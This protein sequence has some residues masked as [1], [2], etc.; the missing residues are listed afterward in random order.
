VLRALPL[1]AALIVA[2]PALAAPPAVPSILTMSPGN[3]GATIT[4]NGSVGA[5]KYTYQKA[6]AAAGLFTDLAGCVAVALT[7]CGGT[8]LVN[9]TAYWFRIRAGNAANEWSAYSTVQGSVTPFG[10]PSGVTA[11]GGTSQV[12]ISWTACPA[13][14]TYKVKRS[15]TSGGPYSV[16][17]SNLPGTSFV[18][19]GTTNGN[20]YYYVVTSRDA[21]GHESAMS[22]QVVGK[23]LAAPVLVYASGGVT[24]VFLTWNAPVNATSYKVRRSTAAGGP[25]ALIGSPTSP[26]FTDGS[27]VQGTTYYYV[28]AAAIGAASLS[29]DSAPVSATPLPKPAA[30]TGPAGT[31][32]VG[33]VTLSW[34]TPNTGM[35]VRAER[36]TDGISGWQ[37]QPCASTSPTGC[38]ADGLLNGTGYFFRLFA[39]NANNLSSDPSPVIGPI[40]PIP[41]WTAAS[42]GSVRLM[43]AAIQ[44][45]TDD[46]VEAYD[47]EAETR[48]ARVASIIAREDP[49][50]IAFQE[51]FQ[52]R[53]RDAL[54]KQLTG[55]PSFVE[56]PGSG[57]M[58]FSKFP[59]E[60]FD[61]PIDEQWGFD[62]Y[63]VSA[64]DWMTPLHG[65]NAGSEFEN[66]KKLVSTAYYESL[67]DGLVRDGDDHPHD[68]YVDFPTGMVRI[69]PAGGAAINVAFTD[70]VDRYPYGN[71]CVEWE[72]QQARRLQ[73]A[74]IQT[75][76]EKTLDEDVRRREPV[77]LLG[78]L[79]I[80]GNRAP[81]HP[82]TSWDIALGVGGLTD[83]GY[84]CGD[85]EQTCHDE[86]VCV[87]V[88]KCDEFGLCYDQQECTPHEVCP[89]T[90]A[91][92][93]ASP[94]LTFSSEW[95]R[96]FDNHGEPE[97]AFFSNA[98]NCFAVTCDP[99]A[100][101]MFTDAW[102]FEHPSAGDVADW[103][104][105]DLASIDE[106]DDPI[107]S[108]YV[109]QTA[110]EDW[111]PLELQSG[112]RMDYILHNQPID[113]DRGA[114]LVATHLR[115][116]F[117]YDPDGASQYYKPAK[118]ESV[119]G[120]VS[121]GGTTTFPFRDRTPI[122][123]HYFVVGDFLF[124]RAARS[125]PLPDDGISGPTFGAEVVTFAG[126]QDRVFP[127]ITLSDPRQSVWFYLAEA[128][129]TV[130]VG[131]SL[132]DQVH[133]DVYHPSDLSTAMPS[134]HQMTSC[135]GREGE[136]CGGVFDLPRPPYYIRYS[137]APGATAPVTFTAG[138]H[139]HKCSDPVSDVCV[140]PNRQERSVTWPA[141]AY[142][143]PYGGT[144]AYLDEMYF[145]AAVDRGDKHAGVSFR[146][147]LDDP[148][149]FALG[150]NAP[151]HGAQ[152]FPACGFA[153]ALPDCGTGACNL[154][155]KGAGGWVG[156]WADDDGDGA[157]DQ[158]LDTG[159]EVSGVLSP[160]V[161]GV[162]N[163]TLLR[164]HRSCGGADCKATAMRVTFTS[165]LYHVVPEKVRVVIEND[166]GMNDDEVYMSI[167][168]D[169]GS[170]PG[171]ASCVP[172]P[173]P[174]VRLPYMDP[175]SSSCDGD[176]APRETTEFGAYQSKPEKTAFVH[177]AF[178]TFCESDAPTSNDFLGE[179]E[180]TD[181]TPLDTSIQV[182]MVIGDID[183]SYWFS[184][185]VRGEQTTSLPQAC[186]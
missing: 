83:P 1:I 56:L 45:I 167:A 125:N 81:D 39:V 8:G 124:D 13:C 97:A 174:G 146:I 157:L 6:T 144:P 46:D 44:C 40:A 121:D 161:A 16:V 162:P 108:Y 100:K 165:R 150:D 106:I 118:Y 29:A 90:F 109:G 168:P 52:D 35:T 12:A 184:Y 164:V 134:F 91:P 179:V 19:N 49:D 3:G 50:V 89:T 139:L 60:P 186:P 84:A 73:L 92:G 76:I 156:A 78:E 130:T 170:A 88:H 63:D 177:R 127:A 103:G 185:R 22:A 141:G 172:D 117:Y 70:L 120:Y 62:Y 79:D 86:P 96:V 14:A 71:T 153:A 98:A 26:A 183:S 42:T 94:S 32:G 119:N 107:Q 59:F 82:T 58:V 178:V 132:P 77:F 142:N 176:T 110:A 143:T 54:V 163:T 55:Y 135:F 69:R 129:G 66:G 27:V 154:P 7:N 9:G 123:E 61:H 37:S 85:D 41:S 131:S 171:E 116:V 36:S 159:N 23:P 72:H 166:F 149:Q 51:V 104:Q 147:E 28:I 48:M 43:S 11:L 145:L 10:I 175:A 152:L 138:F 99:N 133:I 169:A 53:C 34:A 182:P 128:G 181:D 30:P 126:A 160:A 38:T 4:T 20:T 25:F 17:A 33:L 2:S 122:S 5:T 24:Q 67:I 155:I 102:G 87:M 65:V 47:M 101:S 31:P 64:D 74:E 113:P 180:I 115:R 158:L 68:K 18:D 15:A 75:M 111:H 105:S 80:D 140:L 95:Q 114:Y 21:T 148:G 93:T 112:H 136:L 151:G 173:P 137:L 57:L